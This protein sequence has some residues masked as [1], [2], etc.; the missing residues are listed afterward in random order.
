MPSFGFKTD[1]LLIASWIKTI[2]YSY[3]AVVEESIEY[4]SVYTMQV[5][6][7]GRGFHWICLG[8]QGTSSGQAVC[9]I[10]LCIHDA[11]N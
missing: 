11:S 3:L 9:W 8:V 7:S 5:T 6:S 1:R 10:C 4:V 2:A